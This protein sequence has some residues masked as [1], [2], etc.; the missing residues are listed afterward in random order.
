MCAGRHN[1]KNG[2]TQPYVPAELAEAEVA[3]FYGRQ[4]K[5]PAERLAQCR[6]D[7]IEGFRCIAEQRERDLARHGRR[8]ERLEAERRKLLHLHYADKIDP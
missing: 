3:R 8:V 6:D 2:C 7:L 5:V 4:V 1:D